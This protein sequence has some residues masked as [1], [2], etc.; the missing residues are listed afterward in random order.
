[1]MLP[2]SAEVWVNELRLTDF[3][4]KSGWAATGRM[5]ATLA[6]LG[7]F[8][9]AGMTS[10]PGFGSIEKK[11]NERQ[12]EFISSY[13]IATN[14]EIGKFFPEK[15][16]VRLP[17]HIDYS[18]IVSSPEFNP[19]NPDT[20]LKSD[21]ETY[22]TKSE[23]DSVKQMTQD[24]TERKNINFMNMRKDRTGAD[25]PRIYDVENLD[26][27]YSYSETK[28][29]NID[30]EYDVKKIYRGGVGYNFNANPKNHR[31]FAKIPFISKNKN[32]A[33]IRD[34]NFFLYPKMLS[35]R[36]EMNR[37]YNENKLRNKSSGLIIIEPTFMKTFDWSRAYTVRF[38]ITQ[39]LKLDYQANAIARVDEPQGQIDSR[40]KRDTIW[41]NVLDAGRMNNFNH[42]INVNYQIPI[43]KIPMFNWINASARYSGT[44]RWDAP[45]LS[46]QERMG[47]VIENSNTKQ[48]N[49]NLNMVTLYNKI[50]YLRKLNQPKRPTRNQ[51]ARGGN[52]QNNPDNLAQNQTDSTKEKTNYAKIAFDNTLK[53]LM[54]VR[55]V[56][57]SYTEGQ[58]IMLPGFIHTPLYLGNN[59]SNN[60]PGWGFVSG[61]QTDIAE[62]ATLKEW[63]TKD[64][65]FN[66]QYMKKYNQNLNLRA[67][68]EPVKDFRL[69]ITGTRTYTENYS[70]YIKANAEGEYGNYAPQTTGSFNISYF[71]LNTAFIKDDAK[72][73]ND[74]FENLKI[75]RLEIAQRLAAQNPN[76]QGINAE[77]GYPD[78]YGP[79]S[80]NVL[81]PAFLAAYSGTSPSKISLNTFPA[82]PLPNWRM[83]YTGLAKIKWIAD[84]FQTLSVSNAYTCVYGVNSFTSNINYRADSDGFQYVRDALNNFIPQEEIAQV[85]INEQLNPLINFDATLKNSLMAK[86]EFKKSRNLALSFSNSQLTEISS[87]EMIFGV[88]Y[89]F[90]DIS[91]TLNFSGVRRNIKSDLNLKADLSIRDNRTTLRKIIENVNQ[92][93]T[94]QRVITINLS[95]D[96]QLSQ[97]FT[98][99]AFYDQI[100]NKPYVSNQFPTSNINSGISVRFTLN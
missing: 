25:K 34:F 30:I 67:S 62:T 93:S 74:N 53:V 68:I 64:T 73:S 40:E 41:Q 27:T 61:Y 32:L 2:K 76:S 98:I 24:L 82:I 63:I 42:T 51:P 9:I 44:Y 79:N 33:L 48:F 56:S 83:T 45:P 1:D 81:I 7:D 18:R 85:T 71:A 70:A 26:F 4:N 31:P 19:L 29:R 46:L 10:T 28:Q 35:F 43:N 69:D 99:R 37:Q 20:R 65:V 66:S 87:N 22:E 5:R 52:P 36:S 59:L 89:R 39:A 91:M 86:V 92:I 90:K 47:N 58:G 13:D 78:G 6:D 21:L 55:S 3:D 57:V 16:G 60:A 49:S 11:I 77:N 100:L 54:M 17:M 38:D 23:R 95:A 14:I 84:Y 72:Y 97:K 15:W 50:S 75:Y 12:Q 88:G 94:G 96:Y 80:Q 8:S